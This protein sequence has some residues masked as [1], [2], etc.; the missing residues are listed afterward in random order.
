MGAAAVFETAAE[1]PPTVNKSQ[2]CPSSK[3]CNERSYPGAIST[4]AEAEVMPTSRRDGISQQQRLDGIEK[5][6]ERFVMR[7]RTQEVR[8]EGLL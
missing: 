3:P 8:Q 5:T 6:G 1:T 4:F 7:L 2:L